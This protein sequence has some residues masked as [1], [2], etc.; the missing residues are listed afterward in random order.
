[1]L[2]Y[3]P[4]NSATYTLSVTNGT[5]GGTYAYDAIATV[6]GDAPPSGKQFQYWKSGDR[7]VSREP[8]Y[9]FSVHSNVSLEAVYSDETFRDIPMVTV[10]DN[11]NVRSGYQ[12][13]VGQ[14]HIPSGYQYVEHG[15]LVSGTEGVIDLSSSP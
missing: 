8:T 4:S 12:T 11:L 3:V 9:S 10:G 2:Q 7:V 13:Y 15:L 14:F 5:G 1:M 6:V